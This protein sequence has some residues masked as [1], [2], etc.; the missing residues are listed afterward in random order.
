MTVTEVSIREVGPRDGLQIEAPVPLAEKL[1]LVEALVATGDAA[2]EAA[3]LECQPP[4]AADQARAD[5][6]EVAKRACQRGHTSV[7]SRKYVHMVAGL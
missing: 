6:G 4:G 7:P 2:R 1:R 3:P 5:D